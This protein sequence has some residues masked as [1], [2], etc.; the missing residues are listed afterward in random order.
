[1]TVM[2]ESNDVTE[3]T[4]ENREWPAVLTDRRKPAP[5]GWTIPLLP[6]AVQMALTSPPDATKHSSMKTTAWDRVLKVTVRF[7]GMPS[8]AIRQRLKKAGFRWNSSEVAWETSVSG[9]EQRTSPPGWII[10][11]GSIEKDGAQAISAAA[12]VSDYLDIG[13]RWLPIDRATALD[14]FNLSQEEANAAKQQALADLDAMVDQ[15]KAQRVLIQAP[16]YG[17]FW[18]RVRG[19]KPVVGFQGVH[20]FEFNYLDPGTQ[21]LP[22]GSVLMGV[23]NGD[24]GTQCAEVYSVIGGEQAL[25]RLWSGDYKGEY[26][27]LHSTVA[28]ALRGHIPDEDVEKQCGWSQYASADEDTSLSPGLTMD[29]GGKAGAKAAKHHSKW[30]PPDEDAKREVDRIIAEKVK[31]LKTGSLP[32][33]YPTPAK[34][35]ERMVAMAKIR[36]QDWVLEPSAG[37]GDIADYIMREWGGSIRRL[38]VIEPQPVLRDILQWKGHRIV[39]DDLLA[40]RN[41]YD[42]IIMNPPFSDGQDIRHVRHAFDLLRPGGRLVAIVSEAAFRGDTKESKAFVE[43]LDRYGAEVEKLS[44][45]EFAGV[46]SFRQTNVATRM[47][48]VSMP[49]FMV[50]AEGKTIRDAKGNPV[51]LEDKKPTDPP[52]VPLRVDRRVKVARLREDQR[53]DERGATDPVKLVSADTKDLLRKGLKYDMPEE[54]VAAQIEDVGLILAAK[55]RGKPLFLLANAAGTGKTFVLGGAIREL[56]KTGIRKFI[57]V[58]LNENLIKQAKENLKAYGL[59][60]VT[61]LTYSAMA[62]DGA[63]K[64]EETDEETGKKKKVLVARDRKRRKTFAD[65]AVLILDEAHNVK[66]TGGG[67]RINESARGMVAMTLMRESAFTILSSATPYENPVEARYL[68]ATGLFDRFEKTDDREDPPEMRGLDGHA[69]WAILYGA[70]LTQHGWKDFHNATP[71]LRWVDD[72]DSAIDAKAAREWVIRQ[73]IWTQRERAVPKGR[74]V[75]DFP[76]VMAGQD[77]LGLFARTLA[78][79]EVAM[80]LAKVGEGTDKVRRMISQISMHRANL[81]KRLSEHAKVEPALAL[82]R[83][84]L[85]EDEN[86]RVIIFCETRSPW[87]LGRFT[88]SEEYVRVNKLDKEQASRFH[89]ATEMEDLYSRWVERQINKREDDADQDKDPPPFSRGLLYIA[90]ACE[91]VGLDRPMPATAKR[92]REALETDGYEVGEFTGEHSVAARQN[93]KEAWERG[94]IRVLLATMGAGGTGMSF[95]DTSGNAPRLQLNISLP[96]TAKEQ[97]QV[98]GRVCRYGQRSPAAMRWLVLNNVEYEKKLGHRLAGRMRSMGAI[99]K[100]RAIEEAEALGAWAEGNEQDESLAKFSAN[101]IREAIEAAGLDA[102]ALG[103][104]T[105][106]LLSADV[107]DDSTSPVDRVVASAQRE[108]AKLVVADAALS[109]SDA[110]SDAVTLVTPQ[111]EVRE[112]REQLVE[113][114]GK[115]DAVQQVTHPVQVAEGRAQRK[116]PK[117]KHSTL[118]AEMRVLQESDRLIVVPVGDSDVKSQQTKSAVSASDK[119][120]RTRTP[121]AVRKLSAGSVPAQGLTRQAYALWKQSKAAMGDDADRVFLFVMAPNQLGVFCFDEDAKEYIRAAGKGYRSIPK[122]IDTD[123]EGVGFNEVAPIANSQAANDVLRTIVGNRVRE[124]NDYG[125]RN[126]PKR[127]VFAAC[128]GISPAPEENQRANR[129]VLVRYMDQPLKVMAVCLEGNDWNLVTTTWP[130]VAVAFGW[131]PKSME[132]P[133]AATPVSEVKAT[134]E[135]QPRRERKPRQPRKARGVP[136]PSFKP[137]TVQIPMPKAPAPK[138]VPQYVEPLSTAAS[139]MRVTIDS[140]AVPGFGKL[141]DVPVD[142][143]PAGRQVA[144]EI[145]NLR[146]GGSA[147][148]HDGLFLEVDF[149]AAKGSLRLPTRQ[150]KNPKGLAKVAPNT[151]ITGATPP[152]R[153]AAKLPA[154]GLPQG[155]WELWRL[156]GGRYFLFLPN[157]ATPKGRRQSSKPDSRPERSHSET[158]GIRTLREIIVPGRGEL[159]NVPVSMVPK[160]NQL[161]SFRSQEP[162]DMWQVDFAAA[163][164]QIKVS[165]ATQAPQKMKVQAVPEL[166]GEGWLLVRHRG[167]YALVRA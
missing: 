163:E 120:K 157:V 100:G 148:E 53:P 149:A 158:Q 13:F 12:S 1:M 136:T 71:E 140:I 77:W 116:A 68:A 43:W 8:D 48:A 155:K 30:L 162:G 73:G 27:S 154:H 38:H 90:K 56:R 105:D 23:G 145:L 108:T 144:P 128:R 18:A 103:I 129:E 113:A 25:R 66:G 74:C 14:T 22:V 165:T 95:H 127:P 41:A 36:G 24:D 139:D 167:K 110:V 150:G 46:S 135:A 63:D 125:R 159:R 122:L 59:Q 137:P 142:P 112:V 115:A 151:V 49:I 29:Y 9:L 164:G 131:N 28:S 118:P 75:L 104:D 31:A 117:P 55:E 146:A 91:K 5:R 62:L 6:D 107:S 60:G 64:I 4:R 86:R 96:W 130:A 76:E 10:P 92:V 121:Q 123:I 87:W 32:N 80:N 160:G 26:S 138:P 37:K 70:A 42:K 65:N 98:S 124:Q 152:I 143:V 58:T 20:G 34:L 153:M 78:A 83:A 2:V 16:G 82:A 147:G 93:D 133:A 52:V 84:A 21:T 11:E 85:R 132:E 88:L 161:C 57:W 126:L 45:G 67:D 44:S 89:T 97:E 50:D 47:L 99:V 109:D 17:G 40:W 102:K 54:V 79:Y 101:S 33:F 72:K 81:L 119:P 39:S 134:P 106:H 3:S 7:P 166:G 111:Q 94:E 114:G 35:I 61:F 19:V 51:P 156:E 141:R 15:G 69:R